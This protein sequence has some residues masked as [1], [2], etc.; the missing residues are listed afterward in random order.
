VILCQNEQCGV[1][2]KLSFRRRAS[3][4][5]TAVAL[6]A[7][8]KAGTVNSVKASATPPYEHLATSAPGPPTYVAEDY[9][10]PGQP[11]LTFAQTSAILET[12]DRVKPCQ[13]SLV[14]YVVSGQ[15]VRD[16]LLFFTVPHGQGAHV[17]GTGMDVYFPDSGVTVPIRQDVS[18]AQA[19]ERKKQGIQDIDHQP[20][21][22]SSR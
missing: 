16:L 22:H 19:Q 4:I 18:T 9:A 15:G 21:P 17:F 20:C 10:K 12:L 13:R 7:C 11:S 5:V 6:A 1:M 3:C 8:S 2:G 14:R